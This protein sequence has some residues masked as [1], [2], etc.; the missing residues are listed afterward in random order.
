MS[1]EMTMIAAVR[2]FDSIFADLYPSVRVLL[3]MVHFFVLPISQS[4][5]GKPFFPDSGCQKLANFFEETIYEH[6]KTAG[7][8]IES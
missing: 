4:L 1:R 5:Y 3:L 2:V 8:S 7:N 6:Q